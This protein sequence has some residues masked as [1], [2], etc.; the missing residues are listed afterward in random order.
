MS[1]AASRAHVQPRAMLALLLLLGRQL[2]VD[3][4]VKMY[5]TVPTEGKVY[6]ANLDGSDKQ[7]FAEGVDTPYGVGVDPLGGMVY[8]TTRESV[9]A[10]AANSTAAAQLQLVHGPSSALVMLKTVHNGSSNPYEANKTQ[11]PGQDRA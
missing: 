7:V 8:M 3:A 2:A 4:A 10:K 9:H 6:S 11:T 1:A 5:W